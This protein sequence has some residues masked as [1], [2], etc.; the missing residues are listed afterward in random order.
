[1]RSFAKMKPSRKGEITLP[2]T[3]AVIMH[4]S[5]IVNIANMY[6]NVIRENIILAKIS[7]FIISTRQICFRV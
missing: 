6:F 4:L 2:F 7:E 3:D 5:R 1:M